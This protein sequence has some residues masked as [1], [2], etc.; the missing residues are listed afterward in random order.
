MVVYPWRLFCHH[1][2]CVYIAIFTRILA[3][4]LWHVDSAAT[5]KCNVYR[6]EPLLAGHLDKDSVHWR[7]DTSMSQYRVIYSVGE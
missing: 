7:G 6:L 2:P 5:L 3:V 4:I 1:H